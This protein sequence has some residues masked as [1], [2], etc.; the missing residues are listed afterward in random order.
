MRVESMELLVSRRSNG[1]HD[2]VLPGPSVT[3]DG[4]KGYLF[5]KL[6]AA[7]I[8]EAVTTYRS[9]KHRKCCR[10]EAAP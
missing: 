5:F 3:G 6:D 1:P 10:S 4:V 8:T 9:R 2:F 7:Q